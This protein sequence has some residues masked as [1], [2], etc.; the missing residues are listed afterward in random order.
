MDRYFPFTMSVL[1]LA[2]GACSGE[3]PVEPSLVGTTGMSA[4]TATPS[5]AASAN[6]QLVFQDRAGTGL[7]TFA[8]TNTPFGFWIWCQSKSNNAYGTDCTGSVLFL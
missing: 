7:G 6:Q 5:S 4:V 1:V 3:G 2:T 8:G